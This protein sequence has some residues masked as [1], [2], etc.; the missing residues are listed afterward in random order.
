MKKLY[1]FLYLLIAVSLSACSTMGVQDGAPRGYV[2]FSAI[3]NAVPKELPKSRYGNPNSYTVLGRTYYVRKSAVGFEEKGMASWYGTKFYGQMTSTR[4]P[5]NV[6]AMTAAMRTL[7]IPSFVQVTNLQTGKKIIVEVNDRG[8]FKDNR[9]IDLSYAAAGKLGI[10]QKGTGLVEVRAIN[11]LTWHKE[12]TRSAVAEKA[13][14]P[15]TPHVANPQLYVQ[16][17]A[18][19]DMV[20]AKHVLSELH[21]ELFQPNRITTA[22]IHGE[23]FYLVQIGPLSSAAASSMVSKR[24][25][26]LGYKNP[27]LVN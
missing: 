11:P 25:E 19:S 22:E 9:I 23:R 16:V 5:Y 10:L 21:Q 14:V 6:Y 7:P 27:M 12:Q 26:S 20:N 15:V 3:P 18:F 13:P 17:G 8:P 4:V 1:L 2:N 24:L